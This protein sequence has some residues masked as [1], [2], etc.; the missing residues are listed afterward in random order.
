MYVQ[1]GV[2]TKYLDVDLSGYSNTY[3]VR[4]VWFSYMR[5]LI[6]Y[7]VSYIV[8]MYAYDRALLRIRNINVNVNVNFNHR[9]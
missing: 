5:Q 4:T 3:T 1:M 9:R 7:D 8:P 6:S 2:N